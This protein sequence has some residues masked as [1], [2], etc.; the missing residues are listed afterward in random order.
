MENERP[1]EKLLRRFAKRRREDSGPPMEMHPATRRLLQGEVARQFRKDLPEKQVSKESSGVWWPRLAYVLCTVAVVAVVGALFLPALNRAKSTVYLAKKETLTAKDDEALS[2]QFPAVKPEPVSAPT[3][4]ADQFDAPRFGE[5][6]GTLA[7][8][9][10]PAA[11]SAL[12]VKDASV[13]ANGRVDYSFELNHQTSDGDNREELKQNKPELTVFSNTG[14]LQT[15]EPVLN[16]FQVEQSGN[17]LRVIDEDG[18]TYAGNIVAADLK[19]QSAAQTIRKTYGDIA[20]V[21]NDASGKDK[22]A[23]TDS[24]SEQPAN[25]YFFRVTG[26]NRTL[27]QQ[28][29][30]E[31]NIVSTNQ[32][33]QAT[34]PTQSMQPP[35]NIQYYINN[36]IIVGRAQVEKQREIEI[37][38]TPVSP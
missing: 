34:A 21:E 10:Q 30:F 26:T 36:S 25:N 24:Y 20:T 8:V 12:G 37:N 5:K 15:R 7:K 17:V 27:Q 33:L 16:C 13:T 9:V 35:Q 19:A 6:A 14:S 4:V 18:S 23:G 1:I 28:V 2:R 11:R 38:A 22:T 32:P 31:G 3:E 29:V